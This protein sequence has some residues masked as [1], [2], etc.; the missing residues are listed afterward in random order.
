[1]SAYSSFRLRDYRFLLTGGFFSNFG[2]QMMSVAASWDLY[3][4]TRSA[5]VLGNVGL[6]QVAPAV[7][8]S[9]WAGHVADRLDRRLVMVVS[10]LAY[11]ASA[12]TLALSPHSV[13]WIYGCLFVTA[14]ARTFQGPARGAILS[15]IVPP[16]ALGN[17][18]TW[19]S[20]AQEIA[21]VSGPALAGLLLALTS[22]ATVY[23]VQVGCVAITL[24]SFAAI[25]S[26]RIEPHSVAPGAR[27]FLEGLRFVCA[28]KLI[29]SAV[30]LDLFGVLFGGATALLPIFAVDILHAGPGALG[31][32]RAAPSIGAVLMAVTLAHYGRIVHAGRALL[33]V[34]VGFGLAT[35][36]FAFSKSLWLSMLMLILTGVFD[37]V[38]V[39]L[40][41]SLVQ[42]GTPD[43]LRGRV[44]AVNYIFISCSNQL[45]A[46]ESGWTAAWLGAVPSVWLGGVA[47]ILIAAGC[48]AL[49]PQLRRWRQE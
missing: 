25:R 32:L 49:S 36:G 10:Q 21:N 44:L 11:L 30:S 18:I 28:D 42:K 27:A 37:N 9:L 16:D 43:H 7:L 14:T 41:H 3:Q 13:F 33:T 22:T 39:V 46:V 24:V 40:R 38:S 12:L 2:L 1:M 5:M 31:W 34:V 47:T 48:A 17:A 6:V 8:L 15:A 29:L 20:S 26:R 45:G 23:W 19:N 4:Q 35:I